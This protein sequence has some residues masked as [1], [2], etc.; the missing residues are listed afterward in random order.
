MK[1]GGS[2]PRSIKRAFGVDRVDAVLDRPLLRR[3]GQRLIVQAGK[4]Q[5]QQL[6][7]TFQQQF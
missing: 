5:T 2:V 4:V 3:R 1:D 6:G 7:L